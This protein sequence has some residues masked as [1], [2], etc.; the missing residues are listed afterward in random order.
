MIDLVFFLL[1]D[2][3]SPHFLGFLKAKKAFGERYHH[4][5]LVIFLVFF[6]FSHKFFY[7]SL[8]DLIQKKAQNRECT[9]KWVSNKAVISR[10]L[11]KFLSLVQMSY[12]LVFT[13]FTWSSKTPPCYFLIF[14]IKMVNENTSF[15]PKWH[16]S[17][18]H[19]PLRLVEAHIGLPAVCQRSMYVVFVFL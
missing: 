9:G 2:S 6:S 10:V 18:T 4:V 3:V 11:V 15:L 8:P 14:S 13:V 16:T 7:I 5:N 19:A 17:T 12:L 1:H